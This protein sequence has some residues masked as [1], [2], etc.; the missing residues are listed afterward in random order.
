MMIAR[1]TRIYLEGSQAS[2]KPADVAELVSANT[3]NLIS[4][5]QR[6][7]LSAGTMRGVAYGVL[8]AMIVCLNVTISVVS[9]LGGSVA[10]VAEGLQDN[11][12]KSLPAMSG[13]FGVPVM[14]NPGNVGEN[15][16]LFKMTV[17][18]LVLFM[19]AILGL[20]SG[21]IRGGGWTIS[22]GQ[23]VAMLWIAGITSYGTTLLLENT[24]TF[25]AAG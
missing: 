13:G 23:F 3:T 9:S 24:M 10:G 6:R 5:R 11:A 7:A 18:I 20:I 14:D 17:S 2:G 22:T 8:I 4:L 15:I 12:A 16:F 19:I 25:F 1:F 21:R